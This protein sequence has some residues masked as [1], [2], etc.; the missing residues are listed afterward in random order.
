M[1]DPDDA[2]MVEAGHRLVLPVEPVEGDL[3]GDEQLAR[4][5][6]AAVGVPHLVDL[7]HA[8]RR[9]GPQDLERTD[10]LWDDGG[11]V[12]QRLASS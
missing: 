11:D 9:D 1:V 6:L 8:A 2:R 10:G 7:G 12:G 4:E 3:D 5:A